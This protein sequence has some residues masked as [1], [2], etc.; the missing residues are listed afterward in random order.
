[1]KAP[2]ISVKDFPKAMPLG[3]FVTS[4]VSP[5][6]LGKSL[7]S[8]YWMRALLELNARPQL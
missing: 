5:G 4:T 6:V 8:V 2:N 7:R 1:M 3:P